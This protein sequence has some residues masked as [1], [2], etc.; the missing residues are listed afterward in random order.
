[1]YDRLTPFLILKATNNFD[2]TKVLW[3]RK[4]KKN[5]AISSVLF[6][7]SYDLLKAQSG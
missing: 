1:M 6:D 5:L 3:Q 7:D 2:S 4:W